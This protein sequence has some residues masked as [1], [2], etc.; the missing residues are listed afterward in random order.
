MRIATTLSLSVAV[1]LFSGCAQKIAY[2]HKHAVD[3]VKYKRFKKELLHTA[4]DKKLMLKDD[5]K[6]HIAKNDYLSLDTPVSLQT[7]LDRIGE[8]EHKFYYLT[9]EAKKVVI[10][11]TRGF[12]VHTFKELNAYLRS[13]SK[14]RLRIIKNRFVKNLPKVVDVYDQEAKYSKLANIP[15]TIRSRNFDFKRAMRLLSLK[16]G[17]SIIYDNTNFQSS[18]VSGYSMT[19]SSSTTGGAITVTATTASTTT[20]TNA[21]PQQERM[22]LEGIEELANN[23][24]IDKIP[25]SYSGKSVADFLDYIGEA[26]NLYIDVNHKKKIIYISK[27]KPHTFMLQFMNYGITLNDFYE[28]TGGENG[29][30]GATTATTATGTTGTEGEGTTSKIYDL[31]KNNISAILIRNG[32]QP[33][34]VVND[35]T[36]QVSVKCTKKSYQEISD[37]I[38]KI[39]DLFSKKIKLVVTTYQVLIDKNFNSGI[40]VLFARASTTRNFMAMF[41]TQYSKDGSQIEVKKD[42][43]N[44]S[45]DYFAKVLNEIGY[46]WKRDSKEYTLN[47]LVPFTIDDTTQTKY[48]ASKQVTQQA[49]QA[50][51]TINT[52]YNTDVYKEGTQSTITPKINRDGTITL[53]L[54]VVNNEKIAIQK[55]QIDQNTMITLPSVREKKYT[56]FLTLHNGDELIVYAEEMM[57]SA[58]KYK[59]LIPLEDFLIGGNQNSGYVRKEIITTYKVQKF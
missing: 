18:D 9:D 33:S 20:N 6:E 42:T 19:T 51:T 30:E 25:L 58:D 13:V 14:Y 23:I 8:L 16:T 15:F 2:I 40:D 38:K 59:G 32:E 54:D 44:S 52:S 34:Y 5:I 35:L 41:N 12:K 56:R 29:T 4:T 37:Y 26:L 1:L 28:A 22:T 55:E 57:D 10:P 3:E 50:G 45:G 39:N 36:G 47:N 24:D 7:A 49:T 46:I 17:Y 27:Y 48:L 21:K 11:P 53:K 43:P 31:I